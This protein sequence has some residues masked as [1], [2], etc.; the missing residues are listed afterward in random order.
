MRQKKVCFWTGRAPLPRCRQTR[1]VGVAGGPPR[2]SVCLCVICTD[3]P[4]APHARLL[5]LWLQSRGCLTARVSPS[6]LAACSRDG[7]GGWRR[8][9]RQRAICRVL[10]RQPGSRIRRT[11]F[12]NPKIR[13][14]TY[15]PFHLLNSNGRQSIYSAA[16]GLR[17]KALSSWFP[18]QRGGGRDPLSSPC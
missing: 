8:P 3:A 6:P 17:Q 11:A 13:I 15:H 4:N 16:P 10:R 14:C 9:G 18:A 7:Q 2:T 12:G 5:P 1:Q